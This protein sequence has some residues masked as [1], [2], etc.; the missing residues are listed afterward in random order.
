VARRPRAP[1]CGSRNQI[2]GIDSSA[3]RARCCRRSELIVHHG[4]ENVAGNHLRGRYRCGRSGNRQVDAGDGRA[5]EIIV[6]VISTD[7]PMGRHSRFR[8]FFPDCEANSRVTSGQ[9]IR[10]SK[11]QISGL[12]CSVVTRSARRVLREGASRCVR[13]V[14]R[15]NYVNRINTTKGLRA[16]LCTADGKR[17]EV[18][19][20]GLFYCPN[21]PQSWAVSR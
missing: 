1:S 19:P 8:A 18:P 11:V 15:G 13:T 14:A 17:T 6:N 16:P 20:P 4:A 9:S 5:V 7:D 3:R 12:C 10:C 21:A 2:S